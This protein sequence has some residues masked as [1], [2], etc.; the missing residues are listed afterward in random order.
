MTI[1]MM[2]VARAQMQHLMDDEFGAGLTS[3]CR[4]CGG[5]RKQRH[6]PAC[7]ARQARELDA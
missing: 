2:G 1:D 6:C 4:A 3:R 7:L 5:R